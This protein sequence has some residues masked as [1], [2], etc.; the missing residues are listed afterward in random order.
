[1]NSLMATVHLDLRRVRMIVDKLSQVVMMATLLVHI[2]ESNQLYETD[3][4]LLQMTTTDHHC[5]SNA[6]HCHLASNRK[7]VL[8]DHH[9]TSN[10]TAAPADCTKL[11]RVTALIHPDRM[12]TAVDDHTSSIQSNVAISDDTSMKVSIVAAAGTLDAMMTS[13]VYH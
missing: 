1:M 7:A 8:A 11:Y 9:R 6:A 10:Q 4:M 12:T 3:S 5:K 13:A 2:A